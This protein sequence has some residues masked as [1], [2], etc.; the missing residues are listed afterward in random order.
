MENA[1]EAANAAVLADML[2]EALTD[3]KAWVHIGTEDNRP[4]L[5]VNDG[6]ARY[7]VKKVQV[8]DEESK[9][10]TPRWV[11]L[12]ETKAKEKAPASGSANPAVVQAMKEL[13]AEHKASA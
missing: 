4:V 11:N 12:G 9:K 2:A 3:A 5:F 6:G 7:A 1:N 10:L 13:L 8:F